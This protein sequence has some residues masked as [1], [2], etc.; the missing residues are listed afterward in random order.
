MCKIRTAVF[1]FAG[2]VIVLAG[3]VSSKAS[4][5]KAAQ[6]PEWVSVPKKTYPAE[7]YFCHVG[8]SQD[9]TQAELLALEGI[10]AVFGQDIASVET[11]SSRM[12]SAVGS[13]TVA[14]M[15]AKNMQSD[16]VR[17]VDI[18]SLAA[19]EI[20]EYWTD[21]EKNVYAL[22]VMDKQK[23]SAL[24]ASMIS[25]NNEEIERLLTSR[26]DD[27]FSF[28]AYA[29]TDFAREI[30][31]LNETYLSRLSVVDFSAFSAIQKQC[32]TKAEISAQLV[33]IARQIPVYVRFENDDGGRCAAAFAKAFNSFGFRTSR[34][35]DE[36][37]S[38]CGRLNFAET[39]PKDKSTVQCRYFLEASL[40]D[41]AFEQEL[42]SYSLDGRSAGSSYDSAL[43]L[44]FRALESKAA[45]DFSAQFKAF[46]QNIHIY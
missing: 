23:A 27:A 37:Y 45:G 5:P 14:M 36:R 24:Y 46:L 29:C 34:E 4:E 28:E 39:A 38:F 17:K 13:G 42:L 1:L 30:A 43:N 10:A 3:C 40:K 12:E 26:A 15:R 2:T 41:S 20:K 31:S 6:I 25:K 32:R 21:E 9:K 19:A 44:A 16:I 35:K 11:V 18:S 7:R 8:K 22:A 33:E